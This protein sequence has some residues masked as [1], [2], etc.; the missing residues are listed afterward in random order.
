MEQKNS[1]GKSDT[2]IVRE[3]LVK[4]FCEKLSGPPKKKCVDFYVGPEEEEPQDPVPP[5]EAE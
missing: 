1:F 3:I 2:A 4:E 5:K